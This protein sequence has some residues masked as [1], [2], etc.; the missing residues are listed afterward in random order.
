MR[1]VASWLLYWL[2]DFFYRLDELID[3]ASRGPKPMTYE[4]WE[5]WYQE[6]AWRRF[7]RGAS[8][9]CGTSYQ[10]LM[11]LSSR[12]QGKGA[13]PWEKVPDDF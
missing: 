4:Q 13:G 2:G 12:V 1:Y 6:T 11:S 3:P 9:G 7:I 5:A 8:D 10:R